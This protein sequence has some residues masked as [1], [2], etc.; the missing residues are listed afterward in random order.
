MSTIALESAGT[1]EGEL[2]LCLVGMKAARVESMRVGPLL[3]AAA[4]AFCPVSSSQNSTP[5]FWAVWCIQGEVVERM[6]FMSYL[7]WMRRR[8]CWMC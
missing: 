2:Q 7:G 4:R 1:P 5:C 8:L 3:R 6:H